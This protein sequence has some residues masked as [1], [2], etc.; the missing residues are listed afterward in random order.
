MIEQK[1][2]KFVLKSFFTCSANMCKLSK[3][4]RD[5][6][7]ACFSCV[8]TQECNSTSLPFTYGANSCKYLWMFGCMSASRARSIN[9]CS[10]K[11]TRSTALF[12]SSKIVSCSV[13]WLVCCR[14][15]LAI[16]TAVCCRNFTVIWSLRSSFTPEIQEL[17]I[18]ETS[19]SLFLIRHEFSI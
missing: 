4:T 13:A 2:I 5:A 9:C 1:S 16:S 7:T 3:C 14:S 19:L 17:L 15:S 11:R 10:S 6:S 18:P 12:T 8:W